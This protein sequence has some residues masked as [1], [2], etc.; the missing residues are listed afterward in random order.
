MGTAAALILGYLFGSIPFGL[1][2]TRLAGTGD[3]RA[4]GLS[5]KTVAGA[6]EALTWADVLMVEYH[7]DDESQAPVIAEAHARGIGVVVKKGL[8]SGRLPAAGALRFVLSNPHV[9]SVV[10]GGL[11]LDHIRENVAEL[12]AAPP[13]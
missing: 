8:A 6:R 1:L 3:I 7:L 10:V 13:A 11:N 9:A 4:I 2:L 12:A 5:G